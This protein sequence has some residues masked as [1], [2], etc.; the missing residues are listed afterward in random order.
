MS[1][2]TDGL[3]ANVCCT[4]NLIKI[5]KDVI[6]PDVVV[7]VEAATKDAQQDTV[8]NTYEREYQ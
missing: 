5:H 8:T 7:G 3:L 2:R 4:S 1:A 6:E